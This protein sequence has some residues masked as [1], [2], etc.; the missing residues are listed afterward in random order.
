MGVRGERHGMK[1]KR[2]RERERVRLRERED[3]GKGRET[4]NERQE[5]ERGT[6]HRDRGRKSYDSSSTTIID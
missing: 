1:D 3:G 6:L 4:G 5:T 2:H